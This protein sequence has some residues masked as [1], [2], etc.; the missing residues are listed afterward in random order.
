MS[1]GATP[2]FPYFTYARTK[3]NSWGVTAINPDSSDLYVEKIEGDKYFYDGVWYPFKKVEEKFKIRFGGDYTYEY[4]HTH[5][6]VLLEFP[7]EDKGD[8]SIFYPN[9]FITKS[10]LTYS[11]RWTYTEP[12]NSVYSLL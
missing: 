12:T 5:N 10:D 6:G 8:F 7:D 2:G 9:E 1:G 4:K 3:F 11:L